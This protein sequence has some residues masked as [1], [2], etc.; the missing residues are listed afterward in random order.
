MGHTPEKMSTAPS[1]EDPARAGISF[2]LKEGDHF[3]IT[4]WDR[5]KGRSVRR[6][7]TLRCQT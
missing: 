5:N 6:S 3:Q 2:S 4:G 7:R 1:P